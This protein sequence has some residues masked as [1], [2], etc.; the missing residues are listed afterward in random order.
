MDST[1]AKRKSTNPQKINKCRIPATGSLKSF[2]CANAIV[3]TFLSLVGILSKRSSFFLPTFKYFI[4]FIQFLTKKIKA[5][6]KIIMKMIFFRAIDPANYLRDEL[7]IMKL[8][9]NE[10]Y[11]FL[12]IPLKI[13]AAINTFITIQTENIAAPPCTEVFK[14]CIYNKFR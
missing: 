1:T 5:E 4:R 6:K 12:D 13:A 2:V 9:R 8:I 7:F 3:Q 11:Y 10:G 14:S